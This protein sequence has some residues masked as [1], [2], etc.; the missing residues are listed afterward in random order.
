[1]LR[2][3][4]SRY[5]FLLFILL[6]G[7]KAGAEQ[8]T[9]ETTEC[10]GGGGF[11]SFEERRV[12]KIQQ[13]D[14]DHPQ[15]PGEKLYQILLSSNSPL[16]RYEVLWVTRDEAKSVMAQTRDN[17]ES[18]REAR[19]RPDAVIINVPPAP[20]SPPAPTPPP[21]A[22][23][24]PA[25]PAG[26]IQVVAA[27]DAENLRI[28]VLDPPL[29]RSANQVLSDSEIAERLIVGRVHGAGKLV[30]LTMN[31]SPLEASDKGIFRSTLP[32]TEQ[33]TRVEIVAIDENGN[34]DTRDF[35]L[36]LPPKAPTGKGRDA[37]GASAFGRYH[38]L[39]IGI[40]NYAHYRDL[41]TAENDAR[42][43]ETLLS[44]RYGFSTRLLL[45]PTRHDIIKTMSEMR[46]TLTEKDNLLIYYAGHGE[47]DRVNMR[48]HWLP[49]DAEP[50]SPANWISTVDITDAINRM[51][52][53]HIMVIADSCYSGAMN[54]AASSDLDPGISDEARQRWLQV[55]AT[56]RAR[57][58]LTSGGL[59]PV[60]DGGGG[61]HSIFANALIEA[62]TSNDQVLDGGRLYQ[63]VRDQVTSRASAL[64]LD[65]VP[66][67]AA[68]KGSNH[69]FGDF[70]FVAKQ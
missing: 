27:Q 62:L 23:R 21:A 14:C 60:L 65:Q 2:N 6:T 46:K 54:R 31:G 11:S 26:T 33:R 67:Y 34:R 29:T 3:G 25:P 10:Y 48:G 43:I 22:P 24:T 47:Y 19:N 56:N 28:E 55:M 66:E 61:G 52:A 57:I 13:G 18:R 49:A 70:L 5:L 35:W 44:D 16:S 36:V 39:V 38:A 15:R 30:S 7:S 17:R 69:E 42:A 32:V 45:N 41:E 4:G 58:V 63:Q 1:M 12:V 53:K 37:E 40:N 50:D 59:E 9:V 20:S 8:I 68:L 64:G 51:S